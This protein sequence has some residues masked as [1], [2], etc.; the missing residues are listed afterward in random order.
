MVLLLQSLT[1]SS[2][3]SGAMLGLISQ[4][5]PGTRCF[6]CVGVC[7]LFNSFCALSYPRAGP[8]RLALNNIDGIKHIQCPVLIVHGTDDEIVS[9]QVRLLITL[10]L[11]CLNPE[12]ASSQHG[13]ELHQARTRLQLPQVAYP[14]FLLP[15]TCTRYS[16]PFI[17]PTSV[18]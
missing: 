12:L 10:F 14:L 13:V 2:G 8:D 11:P 1:L 7:L 16:P 15:V 18:H 3:L 4:L 5:I 9:Y 6:V 17:L